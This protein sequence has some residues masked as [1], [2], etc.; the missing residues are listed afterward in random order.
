VLIRP[1]VFVVVEITIRQFC[2]LV[3]WA[4]TGEY[5]QFIQKIE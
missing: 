5:P 3:K 1:P 2:R 4:K